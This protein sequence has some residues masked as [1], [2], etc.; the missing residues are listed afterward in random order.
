MGH[1]E[2][3]RHLE[4][5]FPERNLSDNTLKAVVDLALGILQPEV[6]RGSNII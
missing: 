1:R 2:I 6:V 4:E 3:R 5:T